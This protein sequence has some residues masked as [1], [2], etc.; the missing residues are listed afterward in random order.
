MMAGKRWNTE[1]IETLRRLWLSGKSSDEISDLFPERTATS[2]VVKVKRLGLRHTKEQTKAIL[3]RKSSG[4]NNG[5]FGKQGPRKGVV[6]SPETR[7]KISIVARDDFISGKRVRPTGSLNPMFG[8]PGT[9]LGAV[10]ED[11]TRK[12]LSANA[13][14]LW[15][16]RSE[17]YKK[18]HLLK[19]RR[20]WA[21]WVLERRQT[22]IEKV[23]EDWLVVFGVF[24]QSQVVVGFYVVDFLI[25]HSVVEVHGDYWH[26][27]PDIYGSEHLD[28]T[29]RKNIRRDKAKKTFLSRRGYKLLELW[30]RDLKRAPTKCRELLGGFVK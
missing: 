29:Q 8:K 3:S 10:C 12:L 24:F 30:E 4:E 21:R 27:N 25:G 28:R 15:G 13:S 2:I 23:V 11:S 7:K 14:I 16:S 18:A 19:M 1:E 20:G 26:G 17:E 22:W 6:V 5:M 9:R